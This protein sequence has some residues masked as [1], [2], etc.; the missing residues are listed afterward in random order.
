MPD[1]NTLLFLILPAAVIAGFALVLGHCTGR[2]ADRRFRLALPVILALVAG[3]TLVSGTGAPVA[4]LA[5]AVIAAAGVV[6]PLPLLDGRVSGRVRVLAVL[7][8]SAVTSPLVTALLVNPEH[9]PGGTAPLL[10]DRLPLFG[11]IFDVVVGALPAGTPA[12]DL[13][14]SVLLWS[15]FYL[16]CFLFAAIVYSVLR[17]VAVDLNQAKNTE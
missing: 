6:P 11:G 17:A 5:I 2:T 14:F 10:A 9:L 4:V 3:M 7:C 15:G 8:S 16:E 13:A 12:C 1:G